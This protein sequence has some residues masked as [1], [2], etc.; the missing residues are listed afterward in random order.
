MTINLAH[1]A[2]KVKIGSR[3][4]VTNEYHTAITDDILNAGEVEVYKLR[5]DGFVV[6]VTIIFGEGETDEF[7]LYLFVHLFAHK[8][9][10]EAFG[11]ILA[12]RIV[13]IERRKE[14]SFAERQAAEMIERLEAYRDKSY[15]ASARIHWDYGTQDNTATVLVC[16][17]CGRIAHELQSAEHEPTSGYECD[18]CSIVSEYKKK[19]TGFKPDMFLFDELFLME[20]MEKK[21]VSKLTAFLNKDPISAGVLALLLALYVMFIILSDI[22]A[23][24]WS[25]EQDVINIVGL[26]VSFIIFTIIMVDII[27]TKNQ[28]KRFMNN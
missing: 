14:F 8:P 20:K 23:S 16:G 3:W 9:K 7:E 6:T 15:Q 27:R 25:G 1:E 11:N 5:H 13:E 18:H 21:P 22:I 24:N 26:I 12:D 19:Q 2:A 28:T 17:T 4:T 10:Y